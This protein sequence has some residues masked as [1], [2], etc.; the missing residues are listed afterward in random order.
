MPAPGCDPSPSSWWSPDTRTKPRSCVEN[1]SIDA[2]P[3]LLHGKGKE[4]SMHKA[5]QPPWPKISFKNLILKIIKINRIKIKSLKYLEVR[6][7]Y[8]LLEVN[9]LFHLSSEFWSKAKVSLQFYIR[10]YKNSNWG[11]SW[12]L[13]G[14][15]P[16]CSDILLSS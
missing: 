6:N 2:L 1:Q 11:Y 4:L 16:G 10:V 7:L 5:E 13:L 3:E 12:Q 15:A 14:A 8:F 9:F